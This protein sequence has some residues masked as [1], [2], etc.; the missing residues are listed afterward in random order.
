MISESI[1][2]HVSD[3]RGQAHVSSR[4]HSLSSILQDRL[5]PILDQNGRRSLRSS[6]YFRRGVLYSEPSE[7][8]LVGSPSDL[9]LCGAYEDVMMTEPK[10][11]ENFS[12]LEEIASLEKNLVQAEKEWTLKKQLEAADDKSNKPE[13]DYLQSFKHGCDFGPDDIDARMD[14]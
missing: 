1:E 13:D 8:E 5:R 6:K 7:E 12:L 4:R 9:V 14:L 10:K 2:A 3:R 11:N